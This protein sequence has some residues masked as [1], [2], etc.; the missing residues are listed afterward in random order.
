MFKP[1]DA[2][3]P[4]VP[5]EAPPPVGFASAVVL[6][7][8]SALNVTA[9]A[10]V[11]ATV[12]PSAIRA[13]LCVSIRFSASD[14]ATPTLL[15][16]AP[17]VA[18]AKKS[19]DNVSVLDGFAINF[20]TSR[21]SASTVSPPTLCAATPKVASF[22]T[23]TTLTATPAPMPTCVGSGVLPSAS[24]TPTA[25]PLAVVLPT[26]LLELR[27]VNVPAVVMTLASGTIADT[28]AF[29][30]LIATPAATDILPSLVEA[31]R[32][33][34][35]ATAVSVAPCCSASP[36]PASFC[37]VDADVSL[38]VTALSTSASP[39]AG[40]SPASSAAAAPCALASDVTS[41]E[42]API[43]LKVTV[44]AA[45][46]VVTSRSVVDRT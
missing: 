35:S 2:P 9:P 38:L 39:P 33:S 19:S 37:L 45:P 18:E 10:P 7:R 3:R 20:A 41:D 8:L 13:V 25:A 46:A 1:T 44:L 32:P 27:S 34:P 23:L 11:T 43:A 12:A 36:T 42:D 28:V 5:P 29:C 16:P 17:D 26:A 22:L 14:P 21:L 40:A 6:V 15:P 24:S 31:E 30:T 4:T